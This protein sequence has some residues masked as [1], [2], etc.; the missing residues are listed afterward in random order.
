MTRADPNRLARLRA[1]IVYDGRT[2]AQLS[3]LSGVAAESLSRAEDPRWEPSP[4]EMNALEAFAAAHSPLVPVETVIASMRAGQMCIVVDDED[5]ENE[6]DL[7]IPALA[8]DAAAVN[9]MAK[10]GRGLICLALT[11]ERA[12]LLGL[13][14]MARHNQSQHGTAFTTSIEAREGIS[15]GIS[16]A[17]RAL[18][19]ATATDPHKGRGDIVSPGHVFPLVARRGGVLVRA[20][21]TEAAVDLAMLAGQGSA[22]VIC[23]I[24]SDDGTMARMGELFSFARLHGLKIATIR[25][26][27][28]YRRQTEQLI[29]RASETQFHSEIAGDWRVIAYR[30]RIDG[31]ASVALVK[32]KIS[33]DKETLVRM[34]GVS[35]FYD[36]LRRS[37]PRSQALKRAMRQIGA[38]GSGVIVV[39]FPSGASHVVAEIEADGRR[40]PP[41]QDFRDYGIGAQIL[42]DLGVRDM[43]LLTNSHRNT[44]GIE[45]YGLRVVREIPLESDHSPDRP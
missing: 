44:A 4:D 3:K 7:I 23:E 10:H 29:E 8:A 14:P 34:H 9:F 45:G 33:G 25:D 31:S 28:E 42:A 11:R 37:G 35:I 5:R 24:M 17:D 41:G 43:I 22:G 12:D 16:A 19:I 18:T 36:V 32:G 30:N 26:L 40:P 21:H 6:G 13:E 20:G 27:I 1:A 15:T 39:L 38:A 2:P